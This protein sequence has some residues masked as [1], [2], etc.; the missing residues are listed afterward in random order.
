VDLGDV[1]FGGLCLEAATGKIRYR[2]TLEA[3]P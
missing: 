3:I 2:G 1:P